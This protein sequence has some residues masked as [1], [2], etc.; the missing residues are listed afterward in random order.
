M[1]GFSDIT[2]GK[3]HKRSGRVFTAEDRR[4]P[5]T[6]WWVLRNPVAEL[7]CRHASRTA[8]LSM[9]T[10]PLVAA[11][12]RAD[13]DHDACLEALKSNDY[14]LVL[15]ALCI[16]EAAYLIGKKQGARIE[17]LF[18]RSLESFDV[19]AP[20]AAE[21]QRVADLVEEYAD[22][23]LGGRDASV[24]TLADRFETDLLITLDRRHFSVVRTRRGGQFR[25][26]P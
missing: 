4:L 3:Q 26:L 21:W 19:Q 22:F 25:L 17:S 8:T 6:R 10:G 5:E 20:I 15:P 9:A 7:S 16:A 18:L 24:A 14:A 12:N 23:P 2:F 11:A 1:A 13:P